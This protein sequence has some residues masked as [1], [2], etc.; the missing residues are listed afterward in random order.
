MPRPVKWSRD[1]HPIRERAKRS[2]TET[3]SRKDIQILFD[4]GSSSAQNLMKAIGEVQAV[5]GTHFVERASLLAF[6]DEMVVANSVEAA[7]RNRLLQA[8]APPAPQPLLVTLPPDLRNV[9]V[10]DLPDSIRLSAGRLEIHA[11]DTEAILEGL[12]L[13][14]RALQNDLA[15]A[16]AVWDPAPSVNR[17]PEDAELYALLAGLRSNRPVTS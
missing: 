12:A 8:E 9:M 1:L 10:R 16:Q 4:V 2:R 17:T 14:A 6:L 5:G 7:L 3:W 11:P 13:L 15:G